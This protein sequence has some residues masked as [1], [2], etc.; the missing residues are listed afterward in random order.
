MKDATEAY[1]RVMRMPEVYTKLLL[2]KAAARHAL[3]HSPSFS[4]EHHI[5]P[6][7]FITLFIYTPINIHNCTTHKV[8]Y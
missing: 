8:S 5:P 7:N 4:D 2:R 1:W 3:H 6:L